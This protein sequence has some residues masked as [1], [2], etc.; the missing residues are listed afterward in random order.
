MAHPEGEGLRFDERMS[1]LE[2]LLWG[3]EAHD[4]KLRST[5]TVA[6]VFDRSPDPVAVAE[7]V[8]RLTRC[9]PRFR[10]RVTVGPLSTA[11]PRWE[12]DP[13]FDLGRH[14]IRVTAPQ[15]VSVDDL[16]RAAEPVA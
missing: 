7:R 12:P 16:L 6:V 11:P 15:R 5:I 9:L 1:D 4:P 10:D 8:D 3:L 13:D 14:L 2:A